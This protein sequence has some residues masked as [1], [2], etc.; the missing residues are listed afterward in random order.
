MN[1]FFSSTDDQELEDNTKYY[2]LYLS[3]IV[4]NKGESCA[5]VCFVADITKTVT[6]RDPITKEIINNQV[7]TPD[8]VHYYDCDMYVESEEF[9]YDDVIA[10]F[11]E[12]KAKKKATSV[13][14]SGWGSQYQNGY[15]YGYGFDNED[16]DLDV[17]SINIAIPSHYTAW[18]KGF[19]IKDTQIVNV[20][21]TLLD[22]K[23]ASPTIYTVIHKLTSDLTEDCKEFRKI[24]VSNSGQIEEVVLEDFS[25]VF[26]E[27]HKAYLTAYKTKEVKN[28]IYYK[29]MKAECLRLINK[30]I[31]IYPSLDPYQKEIRKALTK[32]TEK[33]FV[34]ALKA[35][36]K[37]V[38]NKGPKKKITN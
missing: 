2:P 12:L 25:L 16:D 7:V 23:T 35:F 17:P 28:P 11:N 3:V 13:T 15:G 33:L 1:T 9:P 14:Y 18:Q 26:D 10:R 5:R 22:L 4:N 30:S 29:M 6:Y 37:A 8:V 32:A 31:M 19:D 36:S 24:D 20:L 34:E 21:A 38:N 27:F